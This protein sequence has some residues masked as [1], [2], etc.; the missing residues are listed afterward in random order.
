MKAFKDFCNETSLPGWSRLTGSKKNVPYWALVILALTVTGLA[1][2]HNMLCDYLQSGVVT[3]LNSTTGNILNA[4][5]PA[6][7]ICNS[8]QIRKSFF[9]GVFNT[10]FDNIMENST[11]KEMY[12]AFVK[13]YFTGYPEHDVNFYKEA[14]SALNRNYLNTTSFRNKKDSL[15]W[16]S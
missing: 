11:L 2:A 12:N 7:H 5:F 4:E 10:S 13:H 1:L 15:L 3:T 16:I 8:Y 6:L 14:V 9:E